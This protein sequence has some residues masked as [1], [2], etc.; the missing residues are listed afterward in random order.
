[1]AKGYINNTSSK[2]ISDAKIVVTTILTAYD[3]RLE[4]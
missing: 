2:I 3:S 1:M 4:N